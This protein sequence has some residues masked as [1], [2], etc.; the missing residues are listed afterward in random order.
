MIGYSLATVVAVSGARILLHFDGSDASSDIWR[1]PDSGDIHPVGWTEA[2]QLKPP[3][4]YK[5]DTTKYRRFHASSLQNAEIAPAR[6][7]KKE[8]RAPIENYFI[9]GMKLE[10]VLKQIPAVIGKSDIF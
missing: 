7:F 10:A 4:G 8:P 1:L 3:T 2:S 9:T 5:Y 6:L